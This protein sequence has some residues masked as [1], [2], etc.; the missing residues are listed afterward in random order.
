MHVVR[1]VAYA[2]LAVAAMRWA[3]ARPWWPNGN[4]PQREEDVPTCTFETYEPFACGGLP[5]RW[6]L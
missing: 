2:V 6:C 4:V 1:L 5:T 3:S